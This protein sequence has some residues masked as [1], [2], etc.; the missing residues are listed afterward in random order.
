MNQDLNIFYALV[1]RTRAGVLDWL[2]DLPPDVFARE[3]QSFAFGSLSAIYAHSADCYLWWVGAVGL[4]AEVRDVKVNDVHALRK[5]FAEVDETVLEA[6]ET[7]TG[8]DDPFTWTSPTGVAETL[9]RRWLL[10]HPMTH[11]FHHKGQALALA[12]VLGHPHPGAPDTDL[13]Q[14]L[15]ERS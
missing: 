10:V 3:H 9:T 14:P 7:F 6:L 13:A 15:G 2:E 12:R 11:E 4:G 5:A 1:R 8:L